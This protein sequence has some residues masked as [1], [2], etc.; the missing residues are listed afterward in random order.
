MVRSRWCVYFT[1]LV[2]Y[3]YCLF[4]TILYFLYIL[5]YLTSSHTN[6]AFDG[7]AV[8]PHSIHTIPKRSSEDYIYSLLHISLVTRFTQPLSTPLLYPPAQRHKV[9]AH[10]ESSNTTSPPNL[11]PLPSFSRHEQTRQHAALVGE[12]GSWLWHVE[13]QPQYEYAG[14]HA[15]YEN[16]PWPIAYLPTNRR[17]RLHPLLLQRALRFRSRRPHNRG[18]CARHA[19]RMREV[20]T[21][22]VRTGRR[23]GPRAPGARTERLESEEAVQGHHEWA[24]AD[25]GSRHML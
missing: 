4:N 19:R 17:R 10:D 16:T 24:A 15:A 3:F 6:Y 14:S 8:D 9:R 12:D 21:S 25:R 11:P 18:H 20:D 23:A 5:L 13:A 2:K 22:R 1:I 7:F